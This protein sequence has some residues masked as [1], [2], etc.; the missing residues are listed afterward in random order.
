MPTRHT[1]ETKA[2]E[3]KANGLT[4]AFQQRQGSVVDAPQHRIER[5]QFF[6][7]E[8]AEDGALYGARLRPDP[9]MQVFARIGQH[10]FVAAPVF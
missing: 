10:Q 6:R 7:V 3:T 9:S 2:T 8:P 4:F 1:I 5:R